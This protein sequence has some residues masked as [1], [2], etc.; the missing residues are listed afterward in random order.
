MALAPTASAGDNARRSR[1]E[2]TMSVATARERFR[3]QMVEA[4][5][6]LLAL[7]AAVRVGREWMEGN[8]KRDP[9]STLQMTTSVGKVATPPYLQGDAVRVLRAHPQVAFELV[10]GL[11]IQ[12]WYE[13]LQ[14]AF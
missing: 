9:N 3:A 10:H 8:V 11:V 13:F 5:G 7:S 6:L 4:N 1:S 14:E 2:V 12:R